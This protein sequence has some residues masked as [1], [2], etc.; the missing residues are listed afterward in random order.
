PVR[1]F[2]KAAL[3]GIEPF[4]VIIMDN[5]ILY[6]CRWDAVKKHCRQL[7][8]DRHYIWSSATLYDE[9]IV[10]QREKWFAAFLNKNTVPNLDDIFLFHR[11][12]GNGDLHN[13]LKMDRDGI[14][15]TVSITSI[16]MNEQ[17]GS[18]YYTDLKDNNKYQLEMRPHPRPSTKEREHAPNRLNPLFIAAEG[19][20][21]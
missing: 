4:T 6:E 12:A 19:I 9:A 5:N 3:A 13:D 16:Q 2:S 10:K 1:Y 17:R 15:S 21:I 14:M 7:K 11:F 18:M 20:S 8:T